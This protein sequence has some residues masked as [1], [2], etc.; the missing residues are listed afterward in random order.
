MSVETLGEAYSAGWGIKVRCA[1]GKHDGMRTIRECVTG[2]EL[3]LRTL[4]WTRGANYPI[5]RLESRLKC[6]SCGSRQ[7]RVMFDIPGNKTSMRA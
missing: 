4:V 3:D 6:P 7:V 1:Y 5:G 2:G